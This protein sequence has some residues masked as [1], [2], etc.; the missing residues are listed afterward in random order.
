MVGL[1]LV[2]VECLDGI[3]NKVSRPQKQTFQFL[4]ELSNKDR[5]IAIRTTPNSS[6]NPH[7]HGNLK[8]ELGRNLKTSNFIDNRTQESYCFL[9]EMLYIIK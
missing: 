2:V 7:H 3:G 5:Y 4:V 9:L 1:R 6:V 8:G